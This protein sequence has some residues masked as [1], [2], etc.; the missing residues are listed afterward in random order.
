MSII[1]LETG[2]IF[3]LILANGA[4][5]MSEIAVVSARKAR[6]QRLAE[7][8]NRKASAALQLAQSPDTFL[9]TVQIGI[10]PREV[11]QPALFVP[12]GAR[13]VDLLQKFKELRTHFA[14]VVDEHGGVAGVCTLRD[15]LEAIVGELPTPETPAEAMIHLRSDGT[16]LLDGMLFLDEVKEHFRITELPGEEEGAAKTLGG[17]IMNTLQRVPVEGDRFEAS[18]FRFEVIDMDG[19]R[20]DKVLVRR[21]KGDVRLNNTA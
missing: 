21:S 9:S 5:A 7:A 16:W 3:F 17:Y 13:P 6:L 11:L 15:I 2:L 4:L 1:A 18:G 20:V 19:R 12:E 8:G 14:L 10:N